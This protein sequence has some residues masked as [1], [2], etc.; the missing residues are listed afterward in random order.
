[1][2]DEMSDETNRWV[3]QGRILRSPGGKEHVLCETREKAVRVARATIARLLTLPRF[4]ID[5]ARGE[6]SWGEFCAFMAAVVGEDGA[7]AMCSSLE[8]TRWSIGWDE[9][10]AAAGEGDA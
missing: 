3:V 1:M 7:S 4:N 2:S 10:I 6:Y 9:V 5:A 8:A